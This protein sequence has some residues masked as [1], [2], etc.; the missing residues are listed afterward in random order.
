MAFEF[1]VLFDRDTR[2]GWHLNMYGVEVS[3]GGSSPRFH[4]ATWVAFNA[5]PYGWVNLMLSE[6]DTP[7]GRAQAQKRANDLSVI[8]EVWEKLL[9]P[10]LSLR[11]AAFAYDYLGRE[12]P[13]WLREIQYEVSWW[14]TDERK[15][16]FCEKVTQ[17]TPEA[18]AYVE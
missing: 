3:S 5:H 8:E 11:T 13:D 2:Y 15:L 14:T 7:E 16:V 12:R 9:Y 18:Y 6:G 10:K 1:E 17:E 4:V